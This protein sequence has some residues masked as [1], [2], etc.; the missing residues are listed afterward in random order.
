VPAN[1]EVEF[2]DPAGEVG[3]VPSSEEIKFDDPARD[4]GLVLVGVGA[5]VELELAKGEVGL[6]IPPSFMPFE[7]GAPALLELAKETGEVV[8][9]GT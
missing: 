2:D 7:G 8:D 4:V 1:G 3:F 9:M 5:N 6:D